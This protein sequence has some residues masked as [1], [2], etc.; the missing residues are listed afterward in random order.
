MDH[1]SHNKGSMINA[2]LPEIKNSDEVLSLYSI[3][4]GVKNKKELLIWLRKNEYYGH[5]QRILMKMDRASMYHHAVTDR[6]IVTDG[7]RYARIHMN[8]RV[9]LDVASRTYRDLIVI[10]PQNSP[11]PHTRSGAK[12]DRSDDVRTGGDIGVFGY[13]RDLVSKL[14]DHGGNSG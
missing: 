6:D 13:L 11:E 8:H 10:S 1:H 12:A 9:V 3:P 7:H 4:E 5:L 2:L 14:I